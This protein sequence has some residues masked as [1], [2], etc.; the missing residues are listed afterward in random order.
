MARPGA[1]GR[2]IDQATVVVRPP[3]GRAVGMRVGRRVG[4]V[5]PRAPSNP[6]ARTAM[7]RPMVASALVL[8]SLL[9]LPLRAQPGPVPAP[10]A[11]PVTRAELVARLD[12]LASAFLAVGPSVGAQVAVVRGRDTLLLRGYGLADRDAQRVTTLDQRF[13]IGSLTKQFT[14]AGIMRLAERGKLSVD[15]DLSRWVPEF[16]LH[17]HRVTLG[18][19]LN[20]TSGIHNYTESPAWRA[21][22]AD[23]LTPLQVADLVARDTFD[24]APGTRFS[25]S[26]T[27][28]TLL[29]LVVER[30]SGEPYAEYVGRELLAPIGMRHTSYCPSHPQG[31]QWA[32]GYATTNDDRVVPAEY[33]SMTHPYA[34]GALC[35]TAGDFVAWQR[36]LAGGRVV[37]PAS[38]ARMTTPDTLANGGRLTYGFGLFVAPYHGH[39]MVMHE[40]G[41]NGFTSSGLRFPDDSLDVVVFSNTETSGS[42]RLAQN[43]ARAVFGMPLMPHRPA[44]PAPDA[45]EPALR[46]ALVGAYDLAL[47]SGGTLVLHVFAEGDGLAAQAE[48]RRK[49]RLLPLGDGGF[50]A[51]YDPALRVTFERAP[52]GRVTGAAVQQGGATFKGPRRP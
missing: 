9:G 52:D 17:G 28:Y 30:A 22:W 46:D 38:Y 33:L 7:T 4:I 34:A 24:F 20:H 3:R 6:L 41:V 8:L 2:F 49:F 5:A 10:A 16:P 23:D 51:A 13:R 29:G 27:G 40:G 12:S 21:R 26:N 50:R 39:R 45:V 44:P 43:L 32:S 47:P 36:A 25:Y 35:S 11:P 1:A 15:D 37:S 14:A 48:G 19:L 18:Q 31:A 42:G